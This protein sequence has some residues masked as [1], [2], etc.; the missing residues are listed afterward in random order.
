MLAP[1]GDSYASEHARKKAVLVR[2]AAHTACRDARRS[3]QQPH[4][5]TPR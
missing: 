2:A 4:G 3:R 5:R 1:R